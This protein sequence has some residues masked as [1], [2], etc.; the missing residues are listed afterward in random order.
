M[1]ISIRYLRVLA[2][3]VSPLSLSGMEKPVINQSASL[4]SLP[5]EIQLKIASETG[6]SL[7]EIGRNIRALICTNKRFS[8]LFNSEQNTLKLMDLIANRSLFSYRDAT[9][10]S[11]TIRLDA[12]LFLGTHGAGKWIKQRLA[13]DKDSEFATTLTEYF[14]VA[15]GN[16]SNRET[17]IAKEIVNRILCETQYPQEIIDDYIRIK[18]SPNRYDTYQS[19][20]FLIKYIPNLVHQKNK[21]GF[22]ALMHATTQRDPE[23]V[24]LLLQAGTDISTKNNHGNT[25][26]NFAQMNFN[27][28]KKYRHSMNDDYNKIRSESEYYTDKK[29]LELLKEAQ[30]K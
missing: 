2:A 12:A 20:A 6:Q 18:Y 26:L 17:K 29:I 8:H 10:K 16:A 14:C 24:N 25:A 13:E 5:T 21:H 7:G 28:S 30:Q 19:I 3:L 22:T 23:T 4:L 11:K 27:T 9:E 1:N 15:A